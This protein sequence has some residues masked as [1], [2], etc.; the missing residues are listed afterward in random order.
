MFVLTPALSARESDGKDTLKN[1]NISHLRI[2]FSPQTQNYVIFAKG[3]LN[4]TRYEKDFCGDFGC[5][6]GRF[7]GL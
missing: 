1:V 2:F 7:G 3:I 5:C 4:F 6:Y